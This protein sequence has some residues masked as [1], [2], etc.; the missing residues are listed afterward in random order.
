MSTTKKLGAVIFVLLF[1]FFLNYSHRSFIRA[2]VAQTEPTAIPTET[3]T[4]SIFITCLQYERCEKQCSGFAHTDNGKKVKYSYSHRIK[5][6][7]NPNATNKPLPEKEGMLMEC[8]EA[9][10]E[11]CIAG[12]GADGKIDIPQNLSDKKY[13]YKYEGMSGHSATVHKDIV[14]PL[15]ITSDGRFKDGSGEVFDWIE[16]QSVNRLEVGRTFKFAQKIVQI[17][18]PTGPA[19]TTANAIQIGS[20]TLK[21][22]NNLTND[23][24]VAI[25]WDPYGKVF[26]AQDLSPL[27]DIPVSLFEKRADGGYQLVTNPTNPYFENPFLT[28]ETGSFSFIVPD[29]IYKL[30]V[31]YNGI[32]Y[33]PYDEA[34]LSTNCQNGQCLVGDQVLYRDLYYPAPVDKTKEEIVQQG[35]VVHRDIPVY[36]AEII[37]MANGEKSVLG[38]QSK[39]VKL[40]GYIYSLDKTTGRIIFK[41]TV[42][43]PFAR[44]N[45]FSKVFNSQGQ[46][47][48][49]RLLTSTNA[50]NKNHFAVEFDQ[51]SLA[52]N[53][54][55]GIV[56]LGRINLSGDFNL[57]KDK[58]YS[59]NALQFEPIVNYLEGIAYDQSGGIMT[60]S[61]IAVINSLSGETV[62]ETRADE[63]GRFKVSSEYLPN[64]PYTIKYQVGDRVVEIT[65]SDFVAKNTDYFKTNN[66]NKDVFNDKDGNVYKQKGSINQTNSQTGNN[67]VFEEITPSP[68]PPIE[69]RNPIWSTI[70]II[71]FLI[72]GVGVIVKF[73]ILKERNN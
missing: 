37:S 24:C 53:E 60:G 69:T 62:Y 47:E 7:V 31:S 70:L 68:E 50:D 54:I 59:V 16:W 28:T 5:I 49:G 14:N 39:D 18:T 67:G 25:Q 72:F 13:R 12:R 23:E 52:A 20:F 22:V 35:E 10:N 4:D 32:Q 21:T 6:T 71:L 57:N 9:Q 43:Y 36:D 42:N 29:G 8:L 27:T 46:Y 38:V 55:F 11:Q 2:E 65:T 3:P 45:L 73:F 30:G 51:S 40:L 66:I 44:I 41:G 63:N 15:T 48:K 26:N 64:K 17:A 19:S 34:L 61:N 1:L 58:P 56:E 33:P